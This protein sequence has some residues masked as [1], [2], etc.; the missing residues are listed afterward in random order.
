[1][2]GSKSRILATLRY[3]VLSHIPVGEERCCWC[4]TRLLDF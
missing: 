4:D 3:A 2:H 1:M